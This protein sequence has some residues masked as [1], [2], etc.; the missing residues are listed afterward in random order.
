[1]ISFSF[2]NGTYNS[3]SIV[4]AE[5]HH[6]MLAITQVVNQVYAKVPFLTTKLKI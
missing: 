6:D 2:L 1:M 4:K 3:F 5:A